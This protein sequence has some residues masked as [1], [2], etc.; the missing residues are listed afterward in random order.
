MSGKSVMLKPK[1]ITEAFSIEEMRRDFPPVI[2][3]VHLARL[4]G[5]SV[6][7]VYVWA[8]AGRLDGSFRKRGKHLLV[9]RDRAIDLIFNGPEWAESKTNEPN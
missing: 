6:K 7:T 3:P 5:I 1:E 2:Q 4:L 9:W 8:A